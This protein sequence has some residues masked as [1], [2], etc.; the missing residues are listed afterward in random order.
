MKAADKT[1]T[2]SVSSEVQTQMNSPTMPDEQV[3]TLMAEVECFLS[4]RDEL[5][6]KIADEIEATERKLAE[7]KKTAASLFP[8]S[9]SNG[10]SSQKAK[11]SKG[12]TSA[13]SESTSSAESPSSVE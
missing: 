3:G 8:E 10:Q 11:K 1:P 9:V 4:K 7:L 5:A 2:P 13:K 6:R 12:K